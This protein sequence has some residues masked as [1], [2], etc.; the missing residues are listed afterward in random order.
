M[1]RLGWT[2]RWLNT[3]RAREIRIFR[4][5][6]RYI[7]LSFK[8]ERNKNPRVVVHVERCTTIIFLTKKDQDYCE[9]GISKERGCFLFD[10][11]LQERNFL[12]LTT[13]VNFLLLHPR[14]TI[15]SR[16]FVRQLNF[17][18]E[19]EEPRRIGRRSKSPRVRRRLVATGSISILIVTLI[20]FLV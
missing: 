18:F 6:P 7:F 9:I 12:F 5:F 13:P 10:P 17:S 19:K 15:V 8:K 4:H 20:V 16:S 11:I 1:F 2:G 14:S 3:W